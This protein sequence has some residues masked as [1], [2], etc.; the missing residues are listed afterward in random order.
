[1]RRSATC[2]KLNFLTDGVICNPTTSPPAQ[3][4]SLPWNKAGFDASQSVEPIV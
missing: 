4:K 3:Q 2:A 1:L